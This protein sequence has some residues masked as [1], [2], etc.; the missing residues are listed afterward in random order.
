MKDMAIMSPSFLGRVSYRMKSI[1]GEFLGF[2][3]LKHAVRGTHTPTFRS[4]A[5]EQE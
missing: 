5:D 1:N 4:P 3:S 2:S